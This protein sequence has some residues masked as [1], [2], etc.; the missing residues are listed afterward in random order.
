MKR[1]T[2]AFILLAC[3]LTA[4]AQTVTGGVRNG[5]TRKPVAGADVV[6]VNLSQG[7][8]EEAR[9]K[10]NAEGQFS[11]KIKNPEGMHMV[12]VH[13]QD[14]T[15]NEQLPPGASTAQVT[16]YNSATTVPEVQLLDYSQVF[17]TD[18]QVLRVIEVYNLLNNSSP[19]VTQQAFTFYAP[20]GAQVRVGQ[21]VSTSGMPV[22]V[23]ATPLSEKN[24]YQFVYPLRPGSTRFEVVYTMPYSGSYKMEPR[25]PIKAMKFYAV[26]PR[27][28]GFK[29]IS[30]GFH[31]DQWS[32]EPSLDMNTNAVDGPAAGQ[33]IAFEI[34]G[35]GLI[36]QDTP[37]QQQGNSRQGPGGG[38]GAPNEKPN[39][40]S[41]GQW[42]FLGVMS[43]FMAAGAVFI[44]MTS[45]NAAPVAAAAV[46]ARGGATSLLD[47]LKEEMFQLESDRLQG[48]VS[49]Q[50]YDAAKGALDK[51]LQRAMKRK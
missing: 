36:P 12:R 15:Y 2:I 28:M 33:P 11:L 23:N 46:P 34:S 37:Q 18:G 14:V 41:S 35:A 44:Y 49:G 5:T 16:V 1:L 22:P 31:Q 45:R 50:E 29:P 17:E 8:D 24:K 39:P 7:M 42:A 21:A 4:T 3:S 13:Y 20:E 25:P 6:L 47:A 51:T 27:T 10:T 48:K 9:V 40:I 30:S 32:V 43:L 38:L 19:P 26:V